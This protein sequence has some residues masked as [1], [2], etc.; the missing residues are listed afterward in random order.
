MAGLQ[1]LFNGVTTGRIQTATP[2]YTAAPTTGTYH[3]NKIKLDLRNAQD[4]LT[5]KIAK[6]DLLLEQRAASELKVKAAVTQLETIDLVQI[7][8]QK[9]SEYARRQTKGRLE[10][11]VGQALTVVYGK[12]HRFIMDLVTR[13]GRPEVDY[14]L[15]DGTTLVQLK[16]PIYDTGGG[17]INIITIALRLGIDEIVGDTAP[18]LL[19][20]IGANVDGEAAVNLAFFLKQYAAQFDRQIIFITHNDALADAAEARIS[21]HKNNDGEAVV[22]GQTDGPG[23]SAVDHYQAVAKNFA[24]PKLEGGANND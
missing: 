5:K 4:A 11:L 12:P 2:N 3:I 19:D 13:S 6:R 23:Y 8:L 9:T 16:K 20:E 1:E 17:K 18:F 15:H 14:Y 21:V 24:I 7:L 10:E 22:K